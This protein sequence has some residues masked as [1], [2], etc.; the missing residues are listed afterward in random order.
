MFIFFGTAFILLILE[1]H[2]LFWIIYS[3]IFL[4]AA[5]R[6]LTVPNYLV[7]LEKKLDNF[8]FLASIRKIIALQFRVLFVMVRQP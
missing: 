5:L 4:A 6:L 1:P 2:L 7:K 8:L 3:P